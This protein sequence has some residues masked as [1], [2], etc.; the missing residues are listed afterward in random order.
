[1]CFGR[2]STRVGERASKRSAHDPFGPA[3]TRVEERA[4]KRLISAQA[5]TAVD[6][7]GQC[8]VGLQDD[9]PALE[10]A[11]GYWFPWLRFA[12]KSKANAGYQAETRFT[13]RADHRA[14]IESCNVCDMRVYE[15]AVVKRDTQAAYLDS[16][17]VPR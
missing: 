10:R 7:L 12:D 3:S 17:G 9:W 11:V 8:V 4:P 14:L 13:L 5:G 16:I 1:M 2:A 15:A 6:R